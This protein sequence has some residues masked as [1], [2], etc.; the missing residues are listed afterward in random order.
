MSIIITCFCVTDLFIT[1][2]NYVQ[3]FLGKLGKILRE[4]IE[5]SPKSFRCSY[6]G[7]GRGDKRPKTVF[8]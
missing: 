1:S 6:V 4:Q 3:R 5:G 8:E 7:V 2:F